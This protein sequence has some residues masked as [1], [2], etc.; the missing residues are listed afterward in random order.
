[1]IAWLTNG[2]TSSP[3][4]S[5]ESIHDDL[6]VSHRKSS[7][8]KKYPTL[9]FSHPGTWCKVISVFTS[10]RKMS[11]LFLVPCLFTSTNPSQDDFWFRKFTS[12]S[13]NLQW[14]LSKFPTF[15]KMNLNSTDSWNHQ[16][17]LNFPSLQLLGSSPC[18]GQGTSW[19]IHTQPY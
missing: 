13:H 16:K 7:N 9:R 18:C 15:L 17:E 6:P 19:T 11:G 3:Q 8:S 10:R 5:P 12:R 1:M 4:S 2:N 14:D